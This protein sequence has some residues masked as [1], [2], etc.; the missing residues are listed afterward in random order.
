M[1]EIFFPNECCN[2]FFVYFCILHFF[3]CFL[4]P[5]MLNSFFMLSFVGIFFFPIN[6]LKIDDIE[7][8]WKNGS[9]LEVT[10]FFFF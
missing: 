5:Y 1:K 8:Q 7:E 4:P 9:S 6:V 2:S 10:S 3:I